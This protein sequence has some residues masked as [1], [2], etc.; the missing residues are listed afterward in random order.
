MRAALTIALALLATSLPVQAQPAKPAVKMWR[1]E[2][3]R[4]VVNELNIF[5][6]TRAYPGQRKELVVGCYLIKH[7]DRY[8]MWDT[9]LPASLVGAAMNDKDPMSFTVGRSLVDHLAQIGVKPAD[10][11]FVGA[12]H[13]HFDHIG[14][15]DSFPQARLLIGKADLDLLSAPGENPL[16]NKSSLKPWLAGAAAKE[17]VT[18]DKDVFGDG[19]VVMISTPGHT[20]GHNA[21][22]VTL[23]SGKKYLL[24]GDL[25]H[26]AEQVAHH[27]VPTFNHDRADTLASMDRFDKLAKNVGATVIIQHE[28]A[29][30]A[31]LP[32]FPQAAE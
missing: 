14:Q 8:L 16:V 18:G 27:G 30:V 19:S 5:S 21:L 10:V 4:G 26:F 23:G 1:L 15:A 6:D 2:C 9:G 3:G 29:D 13:Y 17:G 20:P 28:P 32:A 7:G 12:S 24:T 11:T 31:K 25:Y 22:L